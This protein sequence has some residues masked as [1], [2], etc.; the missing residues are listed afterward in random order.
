M[1]R[2]GILL[3]SGIPAFR[4][5]VGAYIVRVFC[6]FLLGCHRLQNRNGVKIIE[7]FSC[8]TWE[9]RNERPNAGRVSY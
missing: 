7:K 4:S 9:K 6:L 2:T 3:G 8:S 5:F 1:K